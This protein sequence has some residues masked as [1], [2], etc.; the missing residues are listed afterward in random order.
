MKTGLLVATLFAIGLSAVARADEPSASP[1]T[2]ATSNPATQARGSRLAPKAFQAAVAKARPWIVK[3]ETY[4]GVVATGAAAKSLGWTPGDGPSTGIIV[5]DDGWILTSTFHFLNKPQT[6][7]VSTQDGTRRVARLVGRDD[8]RQLALLKVDN[9]KDLPVPVW[10][11]RSELQVGQWS[12]AV[13]FGYGGNEPSLTAG[14]ISALS[15]ISTKAIQTDANLSPANYGGPLL[16]IEGNLIGICSALHPQA[17]QAGAGAQWYDSGIGF[18]VPEDSVKR[19]LDRLKEGQ[20]IESGALGV[21]VTPE[22]DPPLG[23]HVRAVVPESGAD[24]AGI[25]VGD[26]IA[27]VE[28]QSIVDAGHLTIV[29][30]AYAAGDKVNIV[31]V[32]NDEEV[33][34]TVELSRR[35]DINAAMQK[36]APKGK[37]KK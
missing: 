12:V 4:G 36:L 22:G 6:I 19:I 14:I 9:V 35:A 16:D 31:V 2:P 32:R 30:G 8:T 24:K 29:M 28:G 10:K 11:P 26:E 15:R 5:G 34:L 7:T 23:A 37:G 1:L 3:I 21:Q 17:T 27:E 25:K 33:P 20:T 18:A 13:G